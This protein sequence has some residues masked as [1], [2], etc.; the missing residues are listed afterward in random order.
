VEDPTAEANRKPRTGDEVIVSP[1][2]S[3]RDLRL[4]SGNISDLKPEP[5]ETPQPMPEVDAVLTPVP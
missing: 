2:M 3:G 5:A 1:F 4:E